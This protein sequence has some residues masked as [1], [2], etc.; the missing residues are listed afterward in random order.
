MLKLDLRQLRYFQTIAREGQITRAAKKLHVA[1]PPLS[2]SLKALE[3]ELGVKL[4]E[5]N[6]RKMELTEAG[7]ILYQK[8]IHLFEYVEDTCIEVKDTAA[9]IKGILSIGCVK[10]CFPQIPKKL[11]YFHRKY[12]NV[13]FQL[14]EGDSYLLAEELIQRSIDLAIVR[15]P[16]DMSLFAKQSLPSEN[17]IAVIPESWSTTSTAKTITMKKLSE[18]PLLL[19]HRIHGQGQYELIL[20]QFENHRLSPKIICECPDVDMILQ[21]VS[22]QVGATIIPELTLQNHPLRGLKQL[23]IKDHSFP[24]YSA[25]IW[26]K[27]RY[28]PK[29]AKRF[30]ELFTGDK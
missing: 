2:Q 21:L 26:L 12:P 27:N 4:M 8:T 24:S 6:G 3:T 16:L 22:E 5:R 20:E 17:Y 28:L 9:G 23:P 30:I 19:L 7:N 11:K 15:L 25:I 13:H 1:Q 29:S 18:L 10:T 14:K